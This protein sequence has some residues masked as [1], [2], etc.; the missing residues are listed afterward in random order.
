MPVQLVADYNREAGPIGNG[1]MAPGLLMAEANHRIANNLTLIAGWLRLQAAGVRKDARPLSVQEA[2]NLLEEAGSRIETV[3]RLHRLLAHSGQAVTLDLRQYLHDVARAAIDSMSVPGVTTLDAAKS[4][5]CPIPTHQALSVGFIVGEVVTN[6]VK[7]A[8]PA[9][10]SGRVALSCHR[11]PEGASLIQITDD[12]V[13]LPEDFNPRK[14]G[15]L[16]L[17]MVRTLADQLGATL[18]FDSS[19][20]GL[21]VR[22]LLPPYE[23]ISST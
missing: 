9:G 23:L 22:L 14:D 19:G 12:G 1:E 4:S 18:T 11:R 7:Y 21:T 10:V 13:G 2:C 8:H 17:R 3:G 5:T 6:A 16:G 20:F 15:G